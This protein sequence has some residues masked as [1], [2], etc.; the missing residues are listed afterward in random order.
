[1]SVFWK[2]T[3]PRIVEELAEPDDTATVVIKWHLLV[4]EHL[5]R[6]LDLQLPRPQELDKA[7]FTFHQRLHLVKALAISDHP[8]WP[9]IESLNALRNKLAHSLS[10][11]E[12][13]L[14]VRKFLD[15]YLALD[16]NP[17]SAKLVDQLPEASAISRA[18]GF[19]VGI[20]AAYEEA[21]PS[22][23]REQ[24]RADD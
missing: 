24:A 16:P 4:E 9:L 2:H 13:S 7:R 15:Q 19:C 12:R 11:E 1:M 18:G 14:K 6:L 3:M 10:Q 17:E 5:N 20:L 8:A 21:M 23:R 22:M